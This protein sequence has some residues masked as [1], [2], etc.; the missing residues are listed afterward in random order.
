MSLNKITVSLTFGENTHEGEVTRAVSKKEFRY[1]IK[2]KAPEWK[3]DIITTETL[4]P[5]NYYNL[6]SEDCWTIPKETD[7]LLYTG[8][9]SSST[10]SVKSKKRKSTAISSSQTTSTSKKKRK[11]I[12]EEEIE[13]TPEQR[14]S[15]HQKLK[16][17]LLKHTTNKKY[18]IGSK[19]I[20]KTYA[21]EAFWLN[22]KDIA[23]LHGTA[24]KGKFLCRPATKFS[25]NDVVMCA[26][27]KYQTV[28]QWTD[29][30][31]KKAAA[32]KARAANKGNKEK[33]SKTATKKVRAANKKIKSKAKAQTQTQA[34]L[35]CPHPSCSNKVS[36]KC[37]ALDGRHYCGEH[38]PGCSKHKKKK[39][40]KYMSKY[41]LH[42]LPLAQV[43]TAI[44]NDKKTLY[45]QPRTLQQM[46]KDLNVWREFLLIAHLIHL[47]LQ[48]KKMCSWLG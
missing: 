26:V 36:L 37:C 32:K 39:E 30:V 10:C 1:R 4:D 27:H 42:G 33:K 40:Q 21:K 5:T 28:Q 13:L 9:T 15:Q 14:A 22:D 8:S 25:K 11:V 17:V 31:A 7:R 6:L 29:V 24:A 23:N 48:N 44:V 12:K 18:K 19:K 34:S 41:H 45:R 46:A 47:V 2:W 20:Y 38:C 43:V 16:Q 35:K 3:K